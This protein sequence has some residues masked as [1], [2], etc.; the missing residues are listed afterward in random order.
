MGAPA[1]WLVL[2]ARSSSAPDDGRLA[3]GL[4]ALG[5]HAVEEVGEWWVTHLDTP[6][7]DVTE[8]RE[9]LVGLTG[10]A[11]VDVRMRWQEAE[12]WAR[13]WK[14]G[15]GP[16]RVGHR[17][18]VT[19][20]WCVPVADPDDLVLVL[21]PGMAFGNAEHGTTR[22]CLR[23]LE[24]AVRP[25]DR[26]Q[27]VGAGSAVLSIAA[28]LLGAAHVLAVEADPM[29][30]PTAEE[31]VVANGVA[32]RVTVLEARADAAWLTA[33]GSW[34]GIAANIETGVLHPLLPGFAAALRHGGWLI[35]SGILAEQ[36]DPL[37]LDA[38]HHGLALDAVDEDGEWRTALF[39]RS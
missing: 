5:G 39:R 17:F 23:L 22:G 28:A 4:L 13:L 35:L 9:R 30:V 33:G 6:E 34:D 27:D 12:D 21:D 31:N 36:L 32:D 15:L 25:G 38:A 2:E 8:L 37:V 14:E 19:P 10:V 3:E 1:R 18:L 29:A 20:T 7:A 16:R 24:N 26:V 11:D